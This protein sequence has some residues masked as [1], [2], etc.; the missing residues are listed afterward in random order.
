MP[1]AFIS[2][3]DCFLHDAGS[4]H[5]EQ[6]ARLH[7]IKDRMISSGMDSLVIHYDA[8]IAKQED[9][10]R[11]HSPDYVT[12]IIKEIPDSEVKWIDDD[13]AMMSLTIKSALRA[14]GAV[15][16]GVDLVMN[17]AADSAFCAVRPPGHH[18]ER[19][20]AMGFCFFNNVAVGAAHALDTYNLDRVSIIDFDVHHGNGTEDIFKNDPRVLL[21]SSFQHPFYPFTGHETEEKHIINIPLSAGSDGKVFREKVTEMWLPALEDFKPQLILISA[22]FDAHIED[23][24][25]QL[26]FREPDYEWVTAEL[27]MIASKYASGRIV[28]TLE[29]GYALSALGRSVVAHLSQL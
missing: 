11:V 3:Q 2:H 18:A 7:A 27:K 28:S 13:T 16:H 15:V 23:E 22:G 5:P 24:V 12:E 29:G 26:R 25:S 10:F 4:E 8:P 1:I 6:P 9:L 17:G 20:K 14:A 21:C 19:H